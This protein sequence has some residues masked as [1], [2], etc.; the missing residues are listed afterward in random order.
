M[1]ILIHNCSTLYQVAGA[2]ERMKAGEA[3][4]EVKPLENAWL[5]TEG[6]LIKA[7]GTGTPPEELNADRQIDC[8]GGMVIPGF[9]DSHTHLVFAKSREG[10][11]VD[12]IQGLSYEEIA[13]RGGGILNSAARLRAMSEEELLMGAVERAWEIL[14]QGTTSVEIKS[15]YGLTTEDE[16]KM[17]RVANKL[18]Q[19][20]P[21]R[22]KTTFL[23]AHAFP[24]EYRDDQEGYVNLILNE[25][26]PAVAEEKLA[27]YVD[28]FCDRGFFSVEQTE[29]ILEKGIEYGMRPK[30]HANE[31]DFSGGVQAGVKMNALS[32]D[33]LECVGEA[34]IAALKGSETMATILPSTAFF[35]GLEY[36]P[37]RTMIDAGLPVALATDYNP[38]SSPGGS[39]SFILS[40]ACTKM[41]ML[42]EEALSA[43]TLN[44]AYALGLE[45]ETGSLNEGKRADLIITTPM[46]SLAELPYY[47]ARTQVRHVLCGG[48][49]FDGFVSY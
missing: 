40:L 2:G 43:A 39:M 15:G 46:E 1:K 16:L 38:G 48:V 5:L 35:L 36:A 31:L 28:V 14:R 26:I 41:K 17:L 30:I 12:R 4:K 33:H 32:V 6:E 8:E 45:S 23:G 47:F 42:P 18:R 19:F 49:P 20:C 3:M 27:D 7:I 34:E 37:A 25:M 11:Y 9:V 21:I 44:G 10:E 13:K 29:R 22:I 24:A